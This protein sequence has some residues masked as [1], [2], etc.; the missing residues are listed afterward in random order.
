MAAE[1]NAV[2][3]RGMQALIME[4]LVH[5]ELY[6]DKPLFIWQ[7]DFDDGIQ[8]ELVIKTCLDFNKGKAQEEWSY[9]R[10]ITVREGE[11]HLSDPDRNSKGHLAGYVI[12]TRT[13]SL[14]HY[15]REVGKLMVEN[16]ETLPLIIYLPS[17][18]EQGI[19]VETCFN[20]EQLIFSPDF[21]QWAETWSDNTISDFI[22]GNGDKACLTYRWYNRFNDPDMGCSTPKVWLAAN[23]FLNGF[24]KLTK[25]Y[26][27][28]YGIGY[29][30]EDL[31]HSAFKAGMNASGGHISDD[32]ITDFLKHVKSTRFPVSSNTEN[33]ND[34]RDK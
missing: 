18:Y 27:R 30:G 8:Q 32:V 24:I 19:G 23:S 13:L 9:F 2:D 22:R 28:N 14:Q 20:A 5:P 10:L 17:R 21:E 4:R 29:L 11:N 25:N 12:T 7:A 6:A 31:M 33:T 26:R 3:Q 34:N 16:K 15:L 1:L